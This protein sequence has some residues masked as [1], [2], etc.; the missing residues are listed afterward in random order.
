MATEL[1]TGIFSAVGALIGAGGALTANWI[2]A[3]TQ[4][5]QAEAG[6]NERQRETRRNAYA[7][8][9]TSANRFFESSRDLAKVLSGDLT[10]DPEQ[11]HQD[12]LQAWRLLRENEAV[13]E[14]AGPTEVGA[15]ANDLRL[16][17]GKLADVC[18]T[19]HTASQRGKANRR[20][21][22]FDEAVEAVQSARPKFREVANQAV[23]MAG[24]V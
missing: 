6:R 19:W 9:L 14:I 16:A 5:W 22:E 8:F 4:R 12:Y 13:V 15:A 18:D 10:T 23:G 2:T 21:A 17:L 1:I 24:Q 3:R 7:N 20:W 11:T